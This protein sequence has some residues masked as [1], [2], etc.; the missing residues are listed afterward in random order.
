MLVPGVMLFFAL[1]PFAI[2]LDPTLG[3]SELLKIDLRTGMYLLIVMTL[4]LAYNYL[5][6]REVSNEKY[7]SEVNV[8]LRK[9]AL[10]ALP[11]EER[12]L[13]LYK[14]KD[15]RSIFYHFVD[16]DPS[17][18]KQASRAYWNGLAWTSFAD[19]RAISFI[20][21]LIYTLCGFFLDS[22]IFPLCGVIAVVL[23]VASFVFSEI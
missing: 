8:N 10:R 14:W 21:M 13:D 2:A 9:Q 6:L 19:L 20:F 7:H 18:E 15:V 3:W 23:F 11:S 4:G 12:V 5:S 16:K 1:Y 17:L 22:R